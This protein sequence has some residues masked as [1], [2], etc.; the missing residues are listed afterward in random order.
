M[1]QA[2]AIHTNVLDHESAAVANAGRTRPGRCCSKYE[3]KSVIVA[4]VTRAVA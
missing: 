2:I 1:H 4:F 3:R